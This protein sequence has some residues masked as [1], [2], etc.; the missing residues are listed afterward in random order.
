MADLILARDK[1]SSDGEIPHE[2]D[3]NQKYMC[4]VYVS[5]WDSSSHDILKNIKKKQLQC[6]IQ[7]LEGERRVLNSFDASTETMLQHA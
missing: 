1:K 5:E 3:T 4:R 6:P 7:L 2:Y